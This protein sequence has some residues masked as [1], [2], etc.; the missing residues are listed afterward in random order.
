MSVGGVVLAGGQGRRMGGPKARVELG[1]VAL[2][3]RAVATLEEAGCDPVLVADAGDDGPLFA[4]LDPL[5]QLTTDDVVLLACDLPM[6]GPVVSRLP[7][8]AV[9][10]DPDGR[11]QPLCSRWRR[12]DLLDAVIAAVEQSERRMST[13]VDALSPQQIPATADELLNVNTPADLRR[14]SDKIS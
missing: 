6:A 9:G 3:D 4:L 2:V 7:S 1:G 13:L 5:G 10:V 8:N 12:L 14:A 11:V